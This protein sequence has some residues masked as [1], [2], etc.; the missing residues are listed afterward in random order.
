MY[1]ICHDRKDCYKCITETLGYLMSACV[2]HPQGDTIPKTP[3]APPAPDA[4]RISAAD[5]EQ[6]VRFQLKMPNTTQTVN[7]Y[8]ITLS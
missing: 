5:A 7:N 1:F 6:Y 2:L 4:S 8:L 3:G